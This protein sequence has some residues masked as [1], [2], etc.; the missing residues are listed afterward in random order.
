M[1]NQLLQGEF[2]DFSNSQ[3]DF[4]ELSFHKGQFQIWLNGSIIKSLKSFKPIQEKLNF[5][6]S[7]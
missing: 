3:D 7:K 2:L 1:K 6:L 4:I 5:L